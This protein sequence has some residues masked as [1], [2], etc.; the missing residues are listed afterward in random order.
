MVLDSKKRKQSRTG[1][2]RE[3]SILDFFSSFSFPSLSSSNIYDGEERERR[4]RMRTNP[5]PPPFGKWPF[6]NDS[7]RRGLT[8]NAPNSALAPFPNLVSI[9]CRRPAAY[10]RAIKN[11]RQGEKW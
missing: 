6:L 10:V 5:S 3:A 4:R 11:W 2:R 8:D 7:F 9:K 1:R